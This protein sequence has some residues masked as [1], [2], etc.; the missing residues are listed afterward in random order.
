[1]TVRADYSE[2]AL[3]VEARAALGMS[4]AQKSCID[5]I[6]QNRGGSSRWVLDRPVA[7]EKNSWVELEFRRPVLKDSMRGET[8]LSPISG[9]ASKK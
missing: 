3:R 4:H 6:T 9:L 8:R 2:A 7:L 1:M 5:P